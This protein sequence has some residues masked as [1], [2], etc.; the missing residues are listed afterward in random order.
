M[1]NLLKKHKENEITVF[2]WVGRVINNIIDKV[3]L[4]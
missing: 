4:K 3:L 2:Q 1:K